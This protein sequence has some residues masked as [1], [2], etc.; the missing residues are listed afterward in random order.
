MLQPK[1]H[2]APPCFDEGGRLSEC[3]PVQLCYPLWTRAR[4]RCQVRM[5]KRIGRTMCKRESVS[6]TSRSSCWQRKLD[7]I[8]VDLPA[9]WGPGSRSRR[10]AGRSP[11]GRPPFSPRTTWSADV[12]R[13]SI[14]PRV[15]A[16]DRPGLSS[17]ATLRSG[18]PRLVVPGN[19]LPMSIAASGNSKLPPT[20]YAHGR[21][22]R[23]RTSV[24]GSYS[25]ADLAVQS[26]LPSPSRQQSYC[27]SLSKGRPALRRCAE[28]HHR[29]QEHT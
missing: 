9:R 22:R 19:E 3:D 10:R 25:E 21:W 2:L 16:P 23:R 13:S 15:R 29:S 4:L 18:A 11:A 12:P 24:Q 1:N 17:S 8:V 14:A 5:Q 7:H 20:G 26:M 6:S 27:N 28:R